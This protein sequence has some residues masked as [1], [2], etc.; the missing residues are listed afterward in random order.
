MTRWEEAVEKHL[1]DSL[2]LLPCLDRVLPPARIPQSKLL[3]V[4]TG[5]GFPGVVLA[6]ARE[7]L[8]VHPPT[9]P[10][11]KRRKGHSTVSGG[12]LRL[13]GV[14]TGFAH[15]PISADGRICP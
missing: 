3:D 6:V 4:G 11:Q 5:A 15:F 8:Q 14:G 13:P 1:K 2:A 9:P 7:P 10:R 12:R